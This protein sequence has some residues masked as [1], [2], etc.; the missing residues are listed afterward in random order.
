[1]FTGLIQDVGRIAALSRDGNSINFTI[2]SRRLVSGIE[3]GDSVAI[4]GA[5]LTATAIDQSA[6]EFQVTAVTETIGKTKLAALK[7]GSQVNLELSLR[8]TDRLGGHFVQGHVDTTGTCISVVQSGGSWILTV[9][10]PTEF[11][12]LLIE[13]GSIAIDGVSLTAYQRS[14]D[15]FSVSVI[16]HT[17]QETTLSLLKPGDTVNLEFDLIG[18][19]IMNYRK[20]GSSGLTMEKLLDLG[21]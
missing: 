17:W 21:Y 20:T 4:S 9:A 10:Y 18:K 13:K 16:P 15:R 8:P 19:Y 11:A 12:E 3:I 6:G 14:H 2:E 7:Q 5:C 1:M